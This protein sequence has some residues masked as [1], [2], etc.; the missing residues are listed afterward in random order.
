[1]LDGILCRMIDYVVGNLTDRWFLFTNVIFVRS[2]WTEFKLI[3][4]DAIEIDYFIISLYVSHIQGLCAVHY[5]FHSS[6]N[7]SFEKVSLL[8]LLSHCFLVSFSANAYDLVVGALA[9]GHETS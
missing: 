7:T 1:M 4:V 9:G 2:I 6:I 5:T 3:T 8:A